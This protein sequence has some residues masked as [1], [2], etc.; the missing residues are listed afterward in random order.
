MNQE[1]IIIDQPSPHWPSILPAVGKHLL[2]VTGTHSNL[3]A[4]DLL[5][6]GAMQAVIPEGLLTKET[7]LKAANAIS[8]QPAVI[9]A[10]GGG[11]IIDAAKL[12]IHLK[13]WQSSF[14]AA[15]PT[16]AGSGSEATP[17]AVVYA[18]GTKT[19][20][21]DPALLPAMAILHPPSLAG[22]SSTQRAVS[23]IDAM[24]QAVE[25]LWNRNTDASSKKFAALALQ[26]LLEALP[27]FV[28]EKVMDLDKKVLWAAHLSGRAI[29]I[30]RTTGCHALSYYL[31]S[32][33]GV[34]HGQ[35]VAFFVPL[36]FEYN[37]PADLSQIFQVLKVANANEA[38]AKMKNLIA[39]C[40]LATRF[41][42]LGLQVDVDALISSV[43]AERF[44]NN[45]LAFDYERLK[46]LILQHLA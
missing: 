22:L 36:F 8:D 21:E 45:P 27:V 38:A 1:L 32:K 28:D 11:R 46:T 5:K 4:A 25:S 37:A 17:F 24:T 30:T 44:A 26:Y 2:L 6:A 19:S 41:S 29:A 9:L 35:A 40:G 20:L 10:I 7:V 15:L 39:A 33:H 31:T 34:A 12:L 18:S 23:A 16:T 43:N 3:A 13:G 14:F 42:E